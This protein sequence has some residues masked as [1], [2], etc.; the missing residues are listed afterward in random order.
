LKHVFVETIFFID[1]L[2]PFPKP[3]AEKLL[4]RHGC[5]VTL[6]VPWC[7]INEAKRTLDAIIR[8][9]LAFID[10]AGRFMGQLNASYR[11]AVPVDL[12]TVKV[13]INLARD[14]RRDA[15]YD[16]EQCVDGLASKLTVIAPSPQVVQR[17]LSLFPVKSLPP[18]DEM[19][20]GAVLECA[21]GLVA[22][23]VRDIF[24]CNLNFRDFR[25]SSGN[26]LAKAYAKSGIS[27][28]DTF[29]VPL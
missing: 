12:M 24:F 9:D 23:G 21:A 11:A 8:S 22:T 19:V 1:V 3:D 27:Y 6:Y 28:L 16:V 15:L 5:D 25:P 13:F 2:R 29:V 20:L 4:A 18:F 10:G 7:S 14:K 17:T 26:N